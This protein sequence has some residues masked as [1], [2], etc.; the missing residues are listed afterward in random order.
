LDNLDNLALYTLLTQ[1]QNKNY[2]I[3]NI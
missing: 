2:S 1:T 3:N